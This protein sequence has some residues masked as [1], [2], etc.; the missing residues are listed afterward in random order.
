MLLDARIIPQML[1]NSYEDWKQAQFLSFRGPSLFPGRRNLVCA[2]SRQ[3]I[4]HP[5]IRTTNTRMERR[6]LCEN[7]E[8]DVLL[9]VRVPFLFVT[10]PVPTK[11]ETRSSLALSALRL[12][13]R[14]A[15]TKDMIGCCLSLRLSRRRR[16]LEAVS[17]SLSWDCITARLL[18]SVRNDRVQFCHCAC[19]NAGGNSKQSTK[20]MIL[21]VIAKP[22]VFLSG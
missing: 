22:E 15:P 1:G 19:P 12:L 4:Y 18:H 9:L 7:S 3:G 13:C 21:F 10:A 6:E 14:S 16:K 17:L 11:E 20:D 8:R 5:R 2:A